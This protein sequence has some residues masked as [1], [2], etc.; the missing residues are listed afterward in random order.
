MIIPPH[1]RRA[2]AE[3]LLRQ[4][5]GPAEVARRVGAHRVTVSAWARQIGLVGKAGRATGSLGALTQE[6]LSSYLGDLGDPD[7]GLPPI[8][9]RSIEQIASDFGIAAYSARRVADLLSDGGKK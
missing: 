5:L 6:I 8:T 9:P 3:D 4:G 1:P 2:E 7:R